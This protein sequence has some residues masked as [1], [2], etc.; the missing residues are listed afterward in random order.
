MPSI[1]MINIGGRDNLTGSITFRSS[2]VF[3]LKSVCK[4]DK[5]FYFQDN[6]WEVEVKSGNHSIVARC[7]YKLTIDSILSRGLELC[8]QALDLLSVEGKGEIQIEAPGE[9][10]IILFVEENNIILR[11]VSITNLSMGM[12]TTITRID[13]DG[14]IIPEPPPPQINW[15]PAFRFYRLSQGSNDLFEAYRNL[16]LGL[17]ALL[18]Q[19]C[20]KKA[21]EGEKQ[22]LRR[23]LRLISNTIQL[24][25][26][27]PAGN[28]DAIEY[29]IKTQY[30]NVR[31]KL[32]HAKGDRAIIPHQDVNPVFIADAYNSLVMFWR[33]IASFYFN[34]P[35]GGVITHQGFKSMMDAAFINGFTF[36]ASDDKTPPAKEDTEISPL[37]KDVYSYD[38]Y[39]YKNNLKAGHVLLT[40]SIEGA[41]ILKV[42]VIYRIGVKVEDTLCSI[43]YIP[44]GLYI[45]GVD[46]FES[47]QTFRLINKGI[48]KSNF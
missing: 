10:H 46:R 5:V 32:F 33:R 17:E 7:R 47:Y 2:V 28:E 4:V 37:M 18:N 26:F 36:I 48:P 43:N 3:S 13:K 19:I 25:E 39:E 44:D 38:H 20:P 1:G 41:G 21:K 14:N 22:W 42:K 23:A 34:I 12:Q 40:G 9:K 11:E 15:I 35:G 31:C 27:V 16:F 24:S 6:Q 45:H 30:E 8:Q 29:F